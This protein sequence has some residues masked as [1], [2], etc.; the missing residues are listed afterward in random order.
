MKI[1]DKLYEIAIFAEKIAKLRKRMDIFGLNFQFRA[2]RRCDN[3]VDLEKNLM[4]QNE[5]LLP[6]FGADTEENAPST[7]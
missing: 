1:M 6:K 3:P 2:V 7:I 5:Y 4:L